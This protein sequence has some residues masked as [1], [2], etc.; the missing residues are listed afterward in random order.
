[1]NNFSKILEKLRPFKTNKKLVRIGGDGD[2]A[3]LI[4]DDLHGIAAVFSPGIGH[5]SKFEIDIFERYGI[6]SHLLDDSVEGPI[7]FPN[8]LSFTKK[9]LSYYSDENNVT[10][11]DWVLEKYSGND[12]LLLQIDI[13]GAEYESLIVIEDEFFKR[14][15]IIAIELHF[16]GDIINERLFGPV[17]SS[18]VDKLT[19]YHI[20]VHVHPNNYGGIVDLFGT[21]IISA[22]EFTF[23]RKDRC[24]VIGPAEIPHPEDRPNNPNAVDFYLPPI[25]R[26]RL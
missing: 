8:Y 24:L 2:G 25:F 5:T 26:G 13:E 17:F 23:L 3:Y 4:P 6:N 10:L 19:R 12:D 11:S 1:M 15:R 20:P 7:N 22:M 21:Q 9:R 14:F 18:I 16:M